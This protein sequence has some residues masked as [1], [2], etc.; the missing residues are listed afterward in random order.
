M[1]TAA[2]AAL[3]VLLASAS[4]AGER[5]AVR[6]TP[7][8]PRSAARIEDRPLEH[9]WPKYCAD[10]GM[11]GE[12]HNETTISP[13]SMS[14]MHAAWRVTLPGAIA[15]SPTV[16]AGK[17]YVGDWQGNEWELD[18]ASGTAV[19]SVNLGTT[20]IGNCDPPIQGVTSAPAFSVGRIYLAGGDDSFY[21][22]S[23]ETL[24]VLW[25]TKLGDNSP[26]GG[27]YGWSSPSV[28]DD[29]VYQGI[30]SHCDDPFVDGR[31]VALGAASGATVA[32]GDLSQTTDPARFG[33][34]VW[35]SPAIDVAPGKVFVTTASAYA[36][37][38][39]LAYSVVR[40]TL[41]SLAIEDSWKIPLDDYNSTPDADWGSSPTLFH[42]AAGR[43]LVG[44][45]QKDGHY[46]AFDRMH[47]SDGPVWK[48][49]LAIGGDCPTCGDGSISTAAFDGSSLYAGGGRMTVGAVEVRGTVSAL[50]PATGVARWTFTDLHGP[51]LA[52]V[53]VA[54]GVVF[55]TAGTQAV[56][57]DAA[58]GA[59]LWR[60]DTGVILYG[61]IA[62]SD[63]RIFFGDTN[64]NLY[65]FEVTSN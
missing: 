62:V 52:P 50:D 39:G 16:V 28:I 64:G 3:A 21:A 15:S 13:S 60:F 48:T 12:A 49:L 2:G 7:L 10:A 42:D 18:A 17:L 27:Y 34:G 20:P 56:A 41:G 24:Q 44:A 57:L 61:G 54:N 36:Y 30:A 8:N 38:D 14:S 37:D 63:G 53:S 35:S 32:S 9:D 43:L 47:L 65:A 33:A 22:L 46:Y 1:E 23:A 29:L 19:A 11:T 51:V 40:L 31:V 4:L 59:L 26:T 58:T 55:A 6:V 25:K 5:S 45:S